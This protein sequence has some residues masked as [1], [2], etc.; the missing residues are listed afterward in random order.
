LGRRLTLVAGLEQS[1]KGLGTG[2]C[3]N[4]DPRIALELFDRGLC[5]LPIISINA[6][7]IVAQVCELLLEVCHRLTFAAHR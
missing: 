6:T 5:L 1:G 4:R 3:V 7:D 2:D